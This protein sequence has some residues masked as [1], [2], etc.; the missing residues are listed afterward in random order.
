VVDAF[1]LN[2]ECCVSARGGRIHERGKPF[3]FRALPVAAERLAELGV[4]CATLANNHSL[5]FG[6]EAPA[7]TVALLAAAGVATAGA[8]PDLIAARQPAQLTVGDQR[9][10]VVAVADHPASYAARRGR[11]GIA[12]ADLAGSGVPEW[13][14]QAAR[15]VDGGLVLVSVHWG[16]EH[17]AG[18]GAARPRRRRRAGVGGCDAGHGSFGPRA[19]TTA[20]R[21]VTRHGALGGFHGCVWCRHGRG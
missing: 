3:F 7:D 18:S 8:G 10:R 20:V 21:G 12:F 19:V 16:T 13:L 6:P 4:A 14:H 5:D 1:V 11:P 9:I 2:L 15:P 17:V